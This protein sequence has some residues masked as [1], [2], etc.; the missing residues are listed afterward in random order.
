MSHYVLKRTDQGGGY[1][2]E[3]GSKSSYTNNV[4][5][6]RKFRSKEEA[7]AERCVE[8]EVIVPLGHEIGIDP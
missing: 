6:A 5:R 1:V 2:A 7:E 8:N 3:P 4:A